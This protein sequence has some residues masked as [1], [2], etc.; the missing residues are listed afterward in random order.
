MGD[1]SAQCVP[2]I[3]RRIRKAKSFECGM[4]FAESKGR[5]S[6]CGSLKEGLCHS[7][8]RFGPHSFPQTSS[9][10]VTT[11]SSASTNGYSHGFRLWPLIPIMT[12][13]SV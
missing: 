9:F 7:L 6:G 12:V 11:F 13:L 5:R 3:K 10:W 4:K 8:S 2:T 1:L